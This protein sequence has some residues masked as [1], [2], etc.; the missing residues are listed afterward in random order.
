MYT[1]T[2]IKGKFMESDVL[3][4]II[5]NVGADF[6]FT[7]L[8]IKEIDGNGGLE[9]FKK[10]LWQYLQNDKDLNSFLNNFYQQNENRVIKKIEC[11][12]KDYTQPQI[13]ETPF[14]NFSLPTEKPYYLYSIVKD[15]GNS[16]LTPQDVEL[17]V[18]IFNKK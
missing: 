5:E 6:E 3:I 11:L 14:G 17:P 13:I 9:L 16:F 18:L 10:P 2:I 12:I 7:N 4:P 1:L 15:N 8:V